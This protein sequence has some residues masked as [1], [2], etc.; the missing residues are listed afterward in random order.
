MTD[1]ETVKTVLVVAAEPRRESRARRFRHRLFE[2]LS[3]A[4]AEARQDQDR[5]QFHQ[6]DPGQSREQ[7]DR[8]RRFSAWRGASACRPPPKASR[9]A[10]PSRR[11]SRSAA[12]SGRAISSAR[13]CPRRTRT[14][15]SARPLRGLSQNRLRSPL[16]GRATPRDTFCSGTAGT[17]APQ[18][19]SRSF[20]NRLL[21]AEDARPRRGGRVLRRSARPPD[22][23]ANRRGRGVRNS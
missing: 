6:V 8:R 19:Q 15:S 14:L 16:V 17:G 9:T 5:P 4:R 11:C 12:T 22:A 20:A 13:R 7:Q 10:R 23:V 21:H 1:L 3:P 2:P 18:C